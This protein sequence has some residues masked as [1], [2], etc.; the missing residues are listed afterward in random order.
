MESSGNSSPNHTSPIS[1]PSRM[2]E[3]SDTFSR[4]KIQNRGLFLIVFIFAGIIIILSVIL[5]A[6]NSP[7]SVSESNARIIQE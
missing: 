2:E 6:A 5:F 3:H 1:S 7:P 4:A